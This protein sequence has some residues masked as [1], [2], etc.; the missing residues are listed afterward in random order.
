[1]HQDTID[2]IFVIVAYTYDM[3]SPTPSITYHAE[4]DRE[5][6]V[7]DAREHGLIRHLKETAICNLDAIVGPP[8]P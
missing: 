8:R 1:M 7:V 4:Q 5:R 3:A 2:V 6:L